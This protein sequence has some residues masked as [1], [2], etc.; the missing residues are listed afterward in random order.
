MAY[1][2]ALAERVRDCL[3]DLGPIREQK[4]FG[5]LA[6]LCSGHMFVGIVG[7]DLMVR[8]GPAGAEAALSR[9]HTRP[10]NF[11]GKPMRSMVLVEP[12]GTRGTALAEWVGAGLAFAESLPPKPSAR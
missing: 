12:A 2:E 3:P 8:L 5:G 4:M 9:P 11:T 6:F 1:D 10:I 7:E